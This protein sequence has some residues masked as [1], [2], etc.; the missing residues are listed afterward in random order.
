MFQ[1]EENMNAICQAWL[2]QVFSG[3]R[4]GKEFLFLQN[5]KLNDE[6]LKVLAEYVGANSNEFVTPENL[7]KSVR[8]LSKSGRFVG[9]KSEELDLDISKPAASRGSL[10]LESNGSIQNLIARVL[11]R[12][13]ESEKA[14]AADQTARHAGYTPLP[15]NPTAQQLKAADPRALR[16]FIAKKRGLDRAKMD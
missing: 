12:R 3:K 11:N 1:T 7:D 14:E 6:N 9:Q 4:A 10:S 2:A 8:Y 13:V 16:A 5:K 15:D